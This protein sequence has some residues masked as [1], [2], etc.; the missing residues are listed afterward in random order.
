MVLRRHYE[1]AT[2]VFRGRCNA[3]TRTL[4]GCYEDVTRLL[5]DLKLRVLQTIKSDDLVG[6]IASPDIPFDDGKR[7]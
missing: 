7:T 3:V 6:D 5:R 1:G 2:R 4:Q